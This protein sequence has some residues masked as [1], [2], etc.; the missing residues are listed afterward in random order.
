MNNKKIH[1][2][3]CGECQNFHFDWNR[4]W[5]SAGEKY[6]IPTAMAPSEAAYALEYNKCDKYMK[7]FSNN[8]EF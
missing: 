7:G 3:K 6:T 4:H 5:C 8:H 1:K 2:R